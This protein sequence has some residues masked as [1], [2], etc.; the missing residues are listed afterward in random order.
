MSADKCL[1]ELVG[2]HGGRGDQHRQVVAARRGHL[3]G[4]PSPG[5]LG[6]QRPLAVAGVDGLDEPA[7]VDVALEGRRHRPET[8]RSSAARYWAAA[9]VVVTVG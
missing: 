9:S 2:E 4:G 6:H 3:A 5:Q 8:S 7:V 1:R